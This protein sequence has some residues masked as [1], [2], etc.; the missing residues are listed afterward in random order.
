[1]FRF[2][3]QHLKSVQQFKVIVVQA[4]PPKNLINKPIHRLAMDVV[5][6]RFIAILQNLIR[7]F[8][9]KTKESE[10]LKTCK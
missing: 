2:Y 3:F 4:G 1:M 6:I 10:E 9:E 8:V 5:N 7:L